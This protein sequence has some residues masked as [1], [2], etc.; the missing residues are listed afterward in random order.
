M[1][2]SQPFENRTRAG[3]LFAN[4]GFLHGAPF[5]DSSLQMSL[6][7]FSLLVSGKTSLHTVTFSPYSLTVNVFPFHLDVHVKS[8]LLLIPEGTE[9]KRRTSSCSSLDESRD[10][11][12]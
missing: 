8:Y 7:Y 1:P 2:F 4:V 5:P 11:S 12:C 9:E 6:F 10:G 3:Q